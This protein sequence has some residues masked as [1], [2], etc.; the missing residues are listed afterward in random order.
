MSLYNH[1]FNRLSLYKILFDMAGEM[2]LE[3]I[4]NGFRD[5]RATNTL[6]PNI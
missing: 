4:H 3:P 5:R 6:L 2:G 1:T